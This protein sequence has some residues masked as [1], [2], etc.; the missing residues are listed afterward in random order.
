MQ[1]ERELGELRARPPFRPSGAILE[2]D[3]SGLALER[4][5][6]LAEG[7]PFCLIVVCFRNDH[8]DVSRFAIDPP[9]GDD[10]ADGALVDLELQSGESSGLTPAEGEAEVTQPP[11]QIVRA[12]LL[13]RTSIQWLNCPSLCKLG[14][15]A[16]RPPDTWQI[17]V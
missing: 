13:D 16:W 1:P 15:G 5:D 7:V 17:A 12:L 4:R 10:K 11:K 3:C 9:T 14:N 6:D 8:D 2:I